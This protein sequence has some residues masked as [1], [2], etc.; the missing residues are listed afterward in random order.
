MKNIKAGFITLG[1]IFL[2]T[3]GIWYIGGLTLPSKTILIQWGFG[4][5]TVSVFA[6]VI[7][8]FVVLF[9]LVKESL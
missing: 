6:M 4:I 3:Y 5:V 7:G 9:N 2:F 8:G 1:L